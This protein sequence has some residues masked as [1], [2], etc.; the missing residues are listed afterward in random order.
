M[1][2][3]HSIILC[4]P[5]IAIF[6]I[7]CADHSDEINKIVAEIYTKNSVKGTIPAHAFKPDGCSGF[8]NGNWVECCVRHDLVY[9]MGGTRVERTA[10]DSALQK[11]VADKGH[12]FIAGLMH[13]GVR[14]VAADSL[15]VGFRLGL[16]A[17]RPSRNGILSRQTQVQSN[18]T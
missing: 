7:G 10:A 4:I 12:P 5:L 13:S 14:V 9:W 6:L 11:C 8:P 17:V 1:R 15:P 16:P 3:S 2:K 18:F